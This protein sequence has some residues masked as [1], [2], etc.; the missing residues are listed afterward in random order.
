MADMTQTS[1]GITPQSNV[2]MS[3][4]QT[5]LQLANQNF[6]QF[7]T[8]FAFCLPSQAP[9]NSALN[10]AYSSAG[11]T[12]VGKGGGTQGTGR[13]YL[14]SIAVTTNTTATSTYA[15]IGKIYDAASPANVTAAN[16][17]AQIPVSGIQV[18]NL[19]F[20]NGLTI[21]PSSI[22]GQIVSV[23]FINQSPSGKF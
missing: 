10:I 17:M 12:T 16:Y 8:K 1:S 14:V 4:I 11:G 5:A 15:T 23:Y 7:L 20:I 19:P 13:D 22:S 18:Y 9:Y 3:G 6:S 2:D 21:N